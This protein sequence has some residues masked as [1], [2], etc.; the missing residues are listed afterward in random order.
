MPRLSF[1]FNLSVSFLGFRAEN[2]LTGSQTLF[3]MPYPKRG[4]APK[5][6]Q[7][8]V[9]VETTAPLDESDGALPSELLDVDT[10][11]TMQVDAIDPDLLE[12]GTVIESG[13][14]YYQILGL[15]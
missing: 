14:E 10:T 11:D 3:L 9:D 5:E 2:R 12:D 1:S 7:E 15:L 4:S 6:N 8:D 13:G